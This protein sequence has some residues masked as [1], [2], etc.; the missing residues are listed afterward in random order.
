MPKKRIIDWF[1]TVPFL[2]CFILMMLL[3]DLAFRLS[4]ITG[5]SLKSKVFAFV[6]FSTVWMLKHIC[7]MKINFDVAEKGGKSDLPKLII[8]NH[9]SLMDIPLTYV[10]YSEF[11]PRYI[12]KKE[13][14]RFFPLVSVA[15]REM[16]HALIDRKNRIQ[17][18]D[19]IRRFAAD[20]PK[21]NYAAVLFPE[22][23][24][25]RNGQLAPFKHGGFIAMV[26]ELGKVE[27]LPVVIDGSWKVSAFKLMPVPFG[28]NI[29]VKLLPGRIVSAE[30]DLKTFLNN[31]SSEFATVLSDTKTA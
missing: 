13:L 5:G 19:E 7:R 16:E 18:T 24:R 20:M 30:D 4:K 17:A 29:N 3:S 12:S 14:S 11:I 10:A 21:Y 2:L 31:L 26:Q 22:G 27:V 9:Q 6:N 8:S 15:L 1:V 23:T 28:L 25:A